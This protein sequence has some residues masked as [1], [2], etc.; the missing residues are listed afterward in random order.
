MLEI[1]EKNILK[2][3]KLKTKK[4]NIQEKEEIKK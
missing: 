2:K 3:M 4:R 1:F